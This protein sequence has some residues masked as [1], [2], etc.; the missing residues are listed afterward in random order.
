M[1]SSLTRPHTI[2]TGI[3]R[4]N[5]LKHLQ[6]ITTIRCGNYDN[7]FVTG[8][9]AFLP[10]TAAVILTGTVGA[11]ACRCAEGIQEFF[12]NGGRQLVEAKKPSRKMRT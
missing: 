5:I 3:L 6:L 12:V 4:E 2:Q 7:L 1:I 9:S 10:T 8:A 11:L